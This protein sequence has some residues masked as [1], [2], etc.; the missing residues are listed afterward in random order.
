MKNTHPDVLDRFYHLWFAI[1][2]VYAVWAKQ[3]NITVNALFALHIIKSTK[4]CTQQDVC[5][6]L[7][8]PKQTVNSLLKTLESAGYIEKQRTISD[9]RSK[10]I[11]LTSD[12]NNYAEEILTKFHN[13]EYNALKIMT[14][15]QISGLLDGMDIFIDSFKKQSNMRE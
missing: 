1:N 11:T 3:H 9:K 4:D 2:D 15:K 14:D 10:M 8:L 7:M 13:D 12:G 6:M 5:K